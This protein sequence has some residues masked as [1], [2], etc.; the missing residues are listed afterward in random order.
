VV[1]GEFHRGGGEGCAEGGGF[2]RGQGSGER[3]EFGGEAAGVIRLIGFCEDEGDVGLEDG[4]R[5]LLEGDVGEAESGED[6]NDRAGGV[7]ADGR[8]R[9]GLADIEAAGEIFA[10]AGEVGMSDLAVRRA[11]SRLP[12]RAWRSATSMKSASRT[13][14]SASLSG[15]GSAAARAVSC[16]ADSSCHAGVSGRNHQ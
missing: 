12:V 13:Q 9:D 10:I 8:V 6:G 16:W 14:R 1:E 7:A 5:G 2:L 15:A 4:G 11:S 3:L